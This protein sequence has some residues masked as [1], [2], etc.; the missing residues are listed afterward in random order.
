[1]T[2]IFVEAVVP[3]QA[4]DQPANVEPLAAVAVNVVLLELLKNQVHRLPQEI[5][6]GAEPTLP[7]PAPACATVR[8]L[9]A[10]NASTGNAATAIRKHQANPAINLR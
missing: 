2:T 9:Y 1:M 5:P 3:E 10:A 7:L 6:P 8:R 4:P